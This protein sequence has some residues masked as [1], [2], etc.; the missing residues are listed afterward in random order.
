MPAVFISYSRAD[1]DFVHRLHEA[2][3]SRGYDVW[4]DWEDIPPSAE[5]LAE[6]RS[7][8][9]SADGVIY[10]LSLIHI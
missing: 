7:G 10:V 1:R 2:L 3:A 8:V 9:L 4:V 5:W 6:I